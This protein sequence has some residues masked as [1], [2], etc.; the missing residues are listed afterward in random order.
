[1]TH[2]NDWDDEDSESFGAATAVLPCIPVLRER[3]SSARRPLSYHDWQVPAVALVPIAELN[4][5]A[6]PLT[7]PTLGLNMGGKER[8]RR[9]KQRPMSQMYYPVGEVGEED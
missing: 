5:Y 7:L 3:I 2:S 8:E 4:C 9:R 6:L 1:M